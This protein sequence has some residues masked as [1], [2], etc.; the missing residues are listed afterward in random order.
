M[1]AVLGRA[2]SPG[3]AIAAAADAAAAGFDHLNLDLI[4]GTPGESD[5]DLLASVE[6]ALGAGVDHV[7]AYALVVEDGTALARQVR[8]GEVAAPDDDVLARR[9]ELL[10]STGSRPPAWTGTRCRT[11]SRPGGQCRHNLGYWNGGQAVGCGS[12]RALL[13]RRSAM[14]ECQAPQRLCGSTG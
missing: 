10:D 12:R 3:R 13:R 5:D 2:H 9:Y 4:Y 14:V 1:L 6:A 8:R 7:S 11:W